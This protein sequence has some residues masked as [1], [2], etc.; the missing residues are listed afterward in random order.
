VTLEGGTRWFRHDLV[1]MATRLGGQPVEEDL[2]ALRMH[3]VDRP[4]S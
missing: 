4:T 1:A 2:G 3:R